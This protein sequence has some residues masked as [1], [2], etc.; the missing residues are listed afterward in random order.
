MP[1][2]KT[3]TKKDNTVISYII[4]FLWI[5]D[6]VLVLLVLV[7]VEAQHFSHFLENC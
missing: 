2:I 6:G 1:P 7:N 5:K 3:E 4:H